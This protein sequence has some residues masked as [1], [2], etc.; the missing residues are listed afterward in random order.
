[1]ETKLLENK[2]AIVSGAASGIGEEIS[3]L[4]AS[5][6]AKVILIDVAPNGEKIAS[7]LRQKGYWA[8]FKI[9]DVTNSA[10]VKEIADFAIEKT[11]KIDVL[12]NAAGIVDFNGITDTK[13][14]DWDRV[15]AINLKGVFLT[16]KCAIP[17]MMERGGS[18]INVSSISS[19]IFRSSNIGDA[20]SA[21]KAGVNGLTNS[22]AIKYAKY[23][24]RCNSIMPGAIE[25]PMTKESLLE[26]NPMVPLRRIG[27]PQDV[28]YMALFLASDYSSFV[29]ATNIPLAGGAH[30]AQVPSK[31]R[32]FSTGA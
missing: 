17:H 28:A 2:T 26:W 23:G 21:S 8:Q 16:M 15:I 4:F 3:R 29:T 14:E 9:C 22:V 30:A 24:I 18:I 32:V 7:E 13:E 12:V 25:T 31:K 19:V 27:Q 11:Q 6:G 20:Y 5:E 1:M 10:H